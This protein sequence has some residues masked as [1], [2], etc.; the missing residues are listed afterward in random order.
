LGGWQLEACSL[1]R[2]AAILKDLGRPEEA[3]PT[4][5]TALRIREER[6]DPEAKDSRELIAEITSA[7]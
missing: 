1:L 5:E 4:A 6:G 7:L 2:V 3:L